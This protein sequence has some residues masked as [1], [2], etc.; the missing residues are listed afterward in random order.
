MYPLIGVIVGALMVQ[1]ATVDQ[2]VQPS[3]VFK[4]LDTLPLGSI[5]HK[6]ITLKTAK[7]DIIFK[8]MPYK[9]KKNDFFIK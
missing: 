3:V 1:V 9:I 5:Y 8:I 7:K 2:I 6:I 4:M